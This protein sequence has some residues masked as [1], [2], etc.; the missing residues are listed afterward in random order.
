MPAGHVHRKVTISLCIGAS[1]VAAAIS[2]PWSGVSIGVGIAATLAV[3][4]DLDI[5]DSSWRTKRNTPAVGWWLFWMPYAKSLRHRGPMSHW[6]V[7]GTA[8][9]VLYMLLPVLFLSMVAS[10][11][12]VPI[13]KLHNLLVE[14]QDLIWLALLG[15]CI[16][17]TLHWALDKGT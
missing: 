17:D 10:S 16:S 5:L 3:H 8:F 13:E 2:D 1:V 12:G 11:Y 9:R 4:P 7:M 15:M 14:Y 6:P